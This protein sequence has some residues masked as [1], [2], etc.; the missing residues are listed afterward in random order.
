MSLSYDICYTARKI[1]QY[2]NKN[3]EEFGITPEQLV[4]LKKLKEKE[5]VSQKKLA[6][7]V[8]KD[9]NTIKAIIDKLEK[10]EFL[11]REIKKDDKR[12]YLLFV[13]LKGKRLLKE[14]LEFE[15]KSED[16]ILYN[17][18]E[19]KKKNLKEIL[20]AIRDNLK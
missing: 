14:V 11:R 19:D 8:D 13:T 18:S 20:E 3:L 9:Q 10:K 16:D 5:G 17:L 1:Y 12:V 6:L 2:L 7:K 4:V 15:K